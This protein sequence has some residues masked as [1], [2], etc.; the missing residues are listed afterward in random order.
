MRIDS[1]IV[2]Q[3]NLTRTDADQAKLRKACSDFEALFTH[4]LL[5][6]ARKSMPQGGMFGSSNESKIYKSMLDEKMAVQSA[7]GKGMG[8]GEML[9]EQMS[10]KHKAGEVEPASNENLRKSGIVPIKNTEQ[11]V[12][13]GGPENGRRFES[14]E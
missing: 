8:L 13:H 9:Y 10:P 14:I 2:N 6:T 7:K 3:M 11:S 4:M 5:S 12:V 1:N